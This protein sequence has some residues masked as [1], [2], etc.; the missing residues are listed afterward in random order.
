M[1]LSAVSTLPVRLEFRRFGISPYQRACLS[2]RHIRGCV[3]RLGLGVHRHRQG[4]FG[5]PACR[6]QCTA[7]T[8]FMKIQLEYFNDVRYAEVKLRRRIFPIRNK[9]ARASLFENY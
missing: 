9:P 5:W 4:H 2:Q 6:F 8:M 3:E 1:L 7:P